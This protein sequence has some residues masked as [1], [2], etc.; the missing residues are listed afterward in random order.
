MLFRT[1][2]PPE[3]TSEWQQIAVMDLGSNTA[4]LVV[5][6]CIP[7]FAYR[8]Q[9]EIREVVRLREGMTEAGLSKAAIDRGLLTLR[10]FKSFCESIAVDAVIPTATSA[11]RDAANGPAFLKRVHDEIGWDLK[12]LSGEREAYY[13]TIGALNEVPM[14]EGFVIDIGGGSM[15]LSE[16]WNGRY[17]RGASLPLGALALTQRFVQSDPIS[18]K[19]YHAMRDDIRD[20][21][22]TLA[23]VQPREDWRLVGLGGTI[24]NLAK[25][26]SKKQSYPLNT[27]HG[28]RLKRESIDESIALFREL[29]LE[30]REDIPGLSSDRA[31]II[32][33]GAMVIA[34]VMDRLKV[35]SIT[36]SENGIRE[37]VF[38]EQFLTK[39]SFPVVDNVRQFSVLNK[40]RIYQYHQAHAEHVQFL[41]RRLFTQLAPLHGYGHTELEL[42]EAAA[43]LHDIGSIVGYADHHKHSQM[44]IENGGLAGYSPREQALIAL[45][46]RFHRK[47]TP[48]TDDLSAL[49]DKGDDTLL[50]KLSALLRMAEYLERGRSGMVTDI[51]ATWDDDTLTLL[52]H[53]DTTPAI[54]MWDA[55]RNAAPLLK[56]AYDRKV[57]IDCT[58]PPDA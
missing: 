5:M 48:S 14:S 17:E 37:G 10:M 21:L 49:M 47:G 53:A 43:L 11:V 41:A 6:R 16:V 26:E 4:R 32:L 42:L 28:F 46:A 45:I 25:I 3:K 19:E 2:R 8:L 44:L 20:Q 34:E 55:E 22:D 7:G 27:L 9:D 56:K 38:F 39:K 40:A 54:E 58:C 29:P 23:W 30:K 35:D 57:I 33:S 12:I 18:D 31:D 24:R 15:Q 51:E 50:L 36:I 1:K 13:D 52:L